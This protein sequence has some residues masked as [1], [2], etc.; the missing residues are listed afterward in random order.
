MVKFTL[1]DSKVV[2]DPN[3]VLIEEFN[4]IVA[5]GKKNKQEDLSM[6]MLLYV[7]YCCDLSSDNPMR[8]LDYRQKPEQ[9]FN[10]AFRAIKK[11]KLSKVEEE[12]VNAA[13]EAYNMYNE[14]APERALLVIDEKIDQLRTTLEDA[15][16]V[17]ER[18]VNA[19]SGAVTFVSNEK[20]LGN[21]VKQIDEFMKMKISIQESAKK[22]ENTGR[23]RANKKSS[24][25]ERGNLLKN[26]ATL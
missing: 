15:T 26:A 3:I 21:M 18:N 11:D 12:L 5:Y 19:A 6:R 20:I 1:K 25:L 2:I 16:P 17:I 14:N 23:V 7:F 13:M 9:A 10:T 24:A 4:N 8:D 22:L